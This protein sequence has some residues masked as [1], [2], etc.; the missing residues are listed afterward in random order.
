[1]NVLLADDHAAVRMG[2]RALIAG[3]W[4]QARIVEVS[5]GAALARELAERAWDLVVF[6]Q[7]MPGGSGLEALES[8]AAAVP[9]IVFTMHESPELVQRAR[10]AGVRGFVAKSSEPEVLEHALDTV[11]EGGTWFPRSSDSA[12]EHLSSREREVLDGLLE[13]LGPKELGVKLDVSASSVQ[14]HTTRLLAKLGLK[15]SRELFR[16]AAHRGGL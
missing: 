1:M 14:T 4:P 8:A 13:G 3:R 10:E 16:W 7:T 5:D 15:S 12:L 6:D 9:A 2:L 11:V